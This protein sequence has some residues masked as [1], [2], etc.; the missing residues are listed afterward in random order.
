ME[1]IEIQTCTTERSV[2]SDWAWRFQ[3]SFL[4][5]R[6][7]SRA[8]SFTPYLLGVKSSDN[9]TPTRMQRT[10]ALTVR[11]DHLKVWS[12]SMQQVRVREGRERGKKRGREIRW[13]K[14]RERESCQAV[15]Y[16]LKRQ[17][18]STGC[19]TG[20]ETS[21]ITAQT[22]R[23]EEVEKWWKNETERS[24]VWQDWERV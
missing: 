4:I 23:R 10:P 22:R 15:I 6:G 18:N 24:V 5:G 3:Q 16:D 17:I 19:L 21:W 9:L 2:T 13:G 8:C 12:T 11:P 1:K 20:P 14:E 7:T